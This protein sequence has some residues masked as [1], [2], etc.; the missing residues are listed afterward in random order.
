MKRIIILIFIILIFIYCYW[1]KKQNINKNILPFGYQYTKEINTSDK[2]DFYKLLERYGT[3]KDM[4]LTN[5][6]MKIERKYS[7]TWGIKIDK[8]NNIE[9]EMYFYIYNPFSRKIEDDTITVKKLS[10][11]LE[12][13]TKY[14]P[15]MTMYSID[16]ENYKEPNYYYF[17][18]TDN[19]KDVG[20]SEK[21]SELNNHYYRYFPDTID[22]KYEKYI[23]N[24]LINYNIS[25][26]KTVFIADKLI[27][28]YYGIYYD[29]IKYN[30]VEY[31]INKYNYNNDIIK[32]LNKNSNY[33]IS[34]DYNKNTDLVER[35]A[36]YGILY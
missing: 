3:K 8:N 36:I 34:V 20:Y 6:L 25:N 24:K 30:Q 27:R 32:N 35:I 33:S 1:L 11:I 19:I 26:I 22:K 14:K 16:Y 7:P 5:Q 29:G 21:K 12:I 10:E 13:N 28:N 4:E 15:N 18:S 31:F 17:T 2:S 23:D 9:F